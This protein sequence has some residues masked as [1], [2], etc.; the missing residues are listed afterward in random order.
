MLSSLSK[1]TILTQFEANLITF[2]I[3]Q[4]SFLRLCQQSKD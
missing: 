1:S 4:L 3:K 2:T